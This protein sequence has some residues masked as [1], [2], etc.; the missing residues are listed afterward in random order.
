MARNAHEARFQRVLKVRTR[1]LRREATPA[2]QLLWDRLRDRKV[3]GLKIRR[4][5]RLDRFVA[6]FFC[7]EI[8]LVIELDG[9]V[10]EAQADRDAARQEALE[11]GGLR[12]LRFTNAEILDDPKAAILRIVEFA[13]RMR[14]GD[15]PETS[16][17]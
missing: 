7:A 12:L 14:N 15:N 8:K 3:A 13:R 17:I 9:P 11:R 1:Q 6:D 16:S 2:E 5:Q 4:Q 10:H